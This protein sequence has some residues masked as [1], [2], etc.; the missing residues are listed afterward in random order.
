ME[1]YLYMQLRLDTIVDTIEIGFP[2]HT[3]KQKVAQKYGG[4]F[5]LAEGNVSCFLTFL[6]TSLKF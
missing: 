6:Q 2:A 1:F 5:R 3:Q 4:K